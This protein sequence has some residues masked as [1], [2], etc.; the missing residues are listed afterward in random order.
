LVFIFNF[1]NLL[2][3]GI[4]NEQSTKHKPRLMNGFI[5]AAVLV[6]LVLAIAFSGV[7]ENVQAAPLLA[8]LPVGL[9]SSDVYAILAGSG[10]TN[11]GET[12]I[13]HGDIGSSPTPSQTGFA[14]C[15]SGNC[16]WL[17]NGTNHT[18]NDAQTIAAKVALRTAYL[19]AQGRSNTGLISADLGGQ[20]LL[21]GVY[22]DNGAPASLSITGTLTLDAQGDSNAVWIFQ[23]ASTLTA[24]TGSTVR[25]I[26]GA[27]ACNI[28]WQVGSSATLMTGATFIGNILAYASI[29]LQDSVTV[30]GRLL[31]GA[32]ANDH[33]NSR[34]H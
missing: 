12:T 8:E 34:Y 14:P 33:I 17:T 6:S 11:T 27:Q 25:L 21:P 20:T 5:H 13:G 4:M 9:G 3:R 32:Q 29:S 22:Q 16:I 30:T 28:F 2:R 10:L 15:G 23:S 26:N 31:A 7:K 1:K 18:A 19:D 24:Q